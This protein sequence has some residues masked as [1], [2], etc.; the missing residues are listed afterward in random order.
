[1]LPPTIPFVTTLTG[2]W[3]DESVTQA[4]YWSAQLRAAV[5]FADGLEVL[6]QANGPAGKDPIYLEV[7]P[8]KTL[9]TFA[10]ESGRRNGKPSVCLTSLPGLEDSRADTH[11]ILTSLGQLWAHGVAID[12]DGFHRTERRARV[13]LP[14][15]PFERQSYWIGAR[16]GAPA[17]APAPRDTSSWFHRPVWREAPPTAAN[18]AS[19]SDRRILVLD[20]QTGV[21]A[22]VA[23]VLRIIGAHPCVV[24]K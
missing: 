1:L 24:R 17:A 18:L 4:G 7:G 12:W 16:R 9:A 8:G 15:Y 5:R 19:L 6:T 3:A 2:E 20:E 21:G 22:A 14:T 10:T 13:S 11:A 23:D